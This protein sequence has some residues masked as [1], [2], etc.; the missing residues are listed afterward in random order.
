MLRYDHVSDANGITGIPRLIEDI[1]TTDNSNKDPSYA[2]ELEIVNKI[3]GH[4][5]F[6]E[7]TPPQMDNSKQ[8]L[9]QR[10]RSSSL[11]WNNSTKD[12][13]APHAGIFWG[14]CIACF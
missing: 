5:S 9:N 1:V 12:R 10:V 7:G 6:F 11:R 14:F 8:I 4:E 13:S 3:A 2:R